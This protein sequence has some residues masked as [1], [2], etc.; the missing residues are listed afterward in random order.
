MGGAG[1][2]YEKGNNE[3][4]G[5]QVYDHYLAIDETITAVAAHKTE[6]M[7]GWVKQW[8]EAVDQGNGLQA[9][10][11][12]AG[13]PA[14]STCSTS[15]RHGDQDPNVDVCGYYYLPNAHS[16]D[17]ATTLKELQ[18]AGVDVYR[19]T[20]P[21]TVRGC[22]GSGTSSTRRAGR[23]GADRDGD[24]P[25]GTLYVPLAQGQKHWI[26]AVLGENP[27]L[28]FH[29]FYDK[30]TWSYPLVRGLAGNGFLTQKLSSLAPLSP[31]SD[32]VLGTAP[33][34]AQPVYA[35][36]TDSMSGLAMVDELLRQGAAVGRGTAAFDAAGI[37]F[38]TGAALVDGTSSP[39]GGRRG[40]GE[41][42]DAG[43]RP[44]RYPA[45]AARSS[46]RRSASTPA[47]RRR[48]RTPRS[49]APATASA[50]APPTAR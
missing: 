3:N 37:H 8:Q 23:P 28:P 4:Y 40:R 41:V 7:T 33:G 25:A 19:V 15:A 24:A 26:Q 36:N 13:Q 20:A 47:A 12:H 14:A 32:V 50:R 9:P 35:F 48:P 10:G 27:Y 16:G 22:T 2:T 42:A 46:C 1:M 6:L 11:E 17:V 21:L 30:V 49:R 29:D 43:L 44:R 34:T 38:V 39:G 18:R 5:K 45:H 31:V